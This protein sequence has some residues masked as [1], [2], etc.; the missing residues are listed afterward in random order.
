MHHRHLCLL[1]SGPARSSQCFPSFSLSRCVMGTLCDVYYR[2]VFIS[3][4]HEQRKLSVRWAYIHIHIYTYKIT[5]KSCVDV[6]PFRH[7]FLI[8][9]SSLY[10][11]HY[12]S[13][14]SSCPSLYL[15]S[16]TIVVLVVVVVVVAIS[17]ALELF[18]VVFFATSACT[19]IL[20]ACFTSAD[21]WKQCPWPWSLHSLKP[22]TRVRW[23]NTKLN[24]ASL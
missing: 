6:K 24:A 13:F 7:S 22:N 11:I 9:P 18:F 1:T 2:Y 16:D 23:G 12:S 14:P 21:N 17:V 3:C 10:A 19:Y 20:K 15:P 4:V 5:L 8:T